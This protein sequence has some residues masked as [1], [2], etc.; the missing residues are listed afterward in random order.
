MRKNKRFEK[1]IEMKCQNMITR[2]KSSSYD[3][4]GVMLCEESIKIPKH[5]FR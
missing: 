1:Y 3:K 4:K 5:I 2:L